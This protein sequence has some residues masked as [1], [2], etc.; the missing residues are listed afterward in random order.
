MAEALISKDHF[1]MN[2]SY[3]NDTSTDQSAVIHVE[4]TQD[5]LQRNDGWLVHVTRFSCDSMNSVMFVEKDLT[6]TWEI[7]VVDDRDRCIHEF[8]FQLNR[9]YA[10]PADLIDAMNLQGRSM[11]LNRTPVAQHVG[12]FTMGG[13]LREMY[14]F[15]LDAAGRIRLKSQP[16]ADTKGDHYISYKG[17]ASM[18]KLLGFKSFNTYLTHAPS[19]GAG[20]CRC[21]DLLGTIIPKVATPESIASGG[22][23]ESVNEVLRV[24]LAG[25]RVKHLSAAGGNVAAE[26]VQ[27]GIPTMVDFYGVNL[28]RLYP[29]DMGDTPTAA[30]GGAEALLPKHET[31]VMTEWLD[32]PKR[33]ALQI[34]AG[35]AAGINDRRDHGPKRKITMVKYTT[36]YAKSNQ[37]VITGTLECELNRGLGANV[38]PIIAPNYV[39][40]STQWQQEHFVYQANSI[41]GYHYAGAGNWG[42]ANSVAIAAYEP[43]LKDITMQRPIAAI[44]EPGHDMVCLESGGVTGSGQVFAIESIGANRMSFTPD[45]PLGM[46]NLTDDF[47]VNHSSVMFTDRRIP[48]QS[49]SQLFGM[50]PNQANGAG[51]PIAAISSFTQLD[52]VEFRI[53][54][55]Y[56]TNVTLG[57]LIYFKYVTKSVR[58]YCNTTISSER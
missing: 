41:P 38:A 24:L 54:C 37:G 55:A 47:V 1:Y 9:D 4:D 56:P 12:M 17:S 34:H 2:A 49:R 50:R 21:I 31:F 36:D 30:R 42:N 23:H 33:S 48:F 39:P 32:I 18:N 26:Y 20:Y 14:R 6:A 5:I 35:N 51:N 16:S 22:F 13:N 3:Y 15:E 58:I 52:G 27:D 53:H 19:A 10:T 8:D 45:W 29:L 25:V 57:D 11:K 43:V 28:E 44:V 7:R 46:R 40:G